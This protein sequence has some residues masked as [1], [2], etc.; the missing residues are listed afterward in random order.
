M[1]SANELSLSVMQTCGSTVYYIFG[2]GFF[3]GAIAALGSMFILDWFQKRRK[4]QS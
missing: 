2:I 4:N 1:E 3:A